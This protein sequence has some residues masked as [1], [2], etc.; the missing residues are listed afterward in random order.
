M[1]KVKVYI[2]KEVEVEI[3]DKF[4]VLDCDVVEWVKRLHNGIITDEL[5]EECIAEVEVKTGIPFY[6]ENKSLTEY[7]CCVEGKYVLT[8]N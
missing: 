1:K 4:E 5:T 2:T 8:E 7:F 3:N 6:N